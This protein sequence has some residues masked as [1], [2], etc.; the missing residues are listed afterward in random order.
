MTAKNATETRLAEWP[1]CQISGK[2]ISATACLN[3]QGQEGCFG[4]AAST[5][6]C[7]SCQE[8]FVDVSSV[9]LCIECLRDEIAEEDSLKKSAIASKTVGDTVYCQIKKSKI[10]IPMCLAVQYPEGC[11]NCAAPS[12]L[13]E[14]CKGKPV[15]FPQYGECLA[16]SVENQELDDSWKELL[17]SG[18]ATPYIVTEIPIE[19]E[20]PRAPE[21]SKMPETPKVSET[22]KHAAPILTFPVRTEVPAAEPQ[23]K[24]SAL[25]RGDLQI[26]IEKAVQALLLIYQLEYISSKTLSEQLK[27]S[28]G[29][30]QRILAQF[31]LKGFVGKH[32]LKQGRKVLIREKRAFR[33]LS[34]LIPPPPVVETPVKETIEIIKTVPPLV[35]HERIQE[36]LNL[37]QRLLALFGTDAEIFDTINGLSQDLQKLLEQKGD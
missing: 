19:E 23:A 18:N 28:Y 2:N 4:C 21:V 25:T 33:S 20:K 8:A 11:K 22:I 12:R 24:E 5:R 14:R 31:A 17:Q 34:A 29:F 13:C 27:I 32:T 26:G 6:L 37:L 36:Q 10:S 1:Y 7:E 35:D 9:G 16:C 3:A 15:R 30:A